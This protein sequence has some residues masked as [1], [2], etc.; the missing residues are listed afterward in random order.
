[1]TDYTKIYDQNFFKDRNDSTR[2]AAERILDIV[3]GLLPGVSSAAD[4]GCGVGTWLSV[5]FERGVTDLRGFDGHWVDRGLLQIAADAFCESDFQKPIVSDRRFELAISLEV[6]EHLPES[7]ADA[8]VESITRLADFVVFSAAIPGQ[9]GVNHINEQWQSYWAEKF[10]AREFVAF[11]PIR[12]KIW[13]D[14]K[15]SIPYR[16]NIILYVARSRI[17][18]VKLPICESA[19]LSIVHPE[20][21][22]LRNSKSVKQ[23]LIDLKATVAHRLT[24]MFGGG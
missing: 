8:F 23:S 13:S 6:A 16:Q 11:D 20:L 2:Y 1:V 3:L 17:S 9:G 18:E 24:R 4:V 5:L 22:G 12:S 7:C 15:I 14:Q 19:S 10:L 21:Y